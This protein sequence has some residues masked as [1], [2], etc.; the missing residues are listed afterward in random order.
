MSRKKRKL[1]TDAGPSVVGPSKASSRD[2]PPPL[3]RFSAVE[4][5][6]IFPSLS[7]LRN[8]VKQEADL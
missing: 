6:R 2:L 4:W 5:A 7:E 1:L 8:F 3:P